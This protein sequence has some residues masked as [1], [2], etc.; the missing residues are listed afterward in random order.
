MGETYLV[1]ALDVH[2]GIPWV[3]I[4]VAPDEIIPVPL[5]LFEIV[6]PTV[7]D[8]WEA[9]VTDGGDLRLCPAAFLT[10]DFSVRAYEGDPVAKAALDRVRR[11]LAGES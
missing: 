10:P 6:D 11:Q 3:D 1:F 9:R 7:P 8:L 4:E 5:L 2:R